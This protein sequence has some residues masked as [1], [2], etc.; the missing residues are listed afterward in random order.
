MQREQLRR[1]RLTAWILLGLFAVIILLIP[2]G[3]GSPST[4]IALAVGGA[5]LIIATMLNHAGLT[6]A[7]AIF[8]IVLIAAGIMLALVGETGGLEVVDL[9]AYDLLVLT[10]VVAASILPRSAAFVVAVFNICLIVGDF[11]LQPKSPDLL[12][13]INILGVPALLA[14]PIALSVLVAIVAYLWVRGVDEQSSR[15]DRAE[16]VAGLEHAYAQQRQQLEIGV[17][18]I[19]ATHVRIANGDYTARAPL[20]QDHALWQIATSLNNLVNRFRTIAEQTNRVGYQLQRT[21]EEIHRLAVALRDLQVGRRPIWPAPSRTAVDE[22][23]PIFA[24]RDRKPPTL[25]AGQAWE[26][27]MES[28]GSRVDGSNGRRWVRVVPRASANSLKDLRA[29]PQVEAWARHSLRRRPPPVGG[30][31]C[32]HDSAHLSPTTHPGSKVQVWG[33]MGQTPNGTHIGTLVA[34]V[35]HGPYAFHTAH[36]SSAGSGHSPCVRRELAVA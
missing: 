17:Q 27:G 18:Q 21:E 29:G 25:P 13:Q 35:S 36:W 22:L 8:L 1:N 6:T 19:L 5:G 30:H 28:D 11:F 14:R 3:I 10:V 20:S 32:H 7:A 9:P 12:Q 23:L 15:A 31:T 16:E 4:V 34:F 26:G 2:T 24:S 33:R